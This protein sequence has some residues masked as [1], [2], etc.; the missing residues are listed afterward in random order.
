MT[1]K[2]YLNNRYTKGTAERYYRDILNYLEAVTQEKALNATYGDIMDYVGE[3]RMKY[4]NPETIKVIIQSIKKCNIIGQEALPNGQL[5]YI[6]NSIYN[7]II[8]QLS[9]VTKVD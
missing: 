7:Q 3:L 6:G 2:E 8:R 5:R 9:G 4:K 1:L